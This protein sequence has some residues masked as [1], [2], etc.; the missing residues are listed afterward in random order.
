MYKIIF[1]TRLFFILFNT[2]LKVN[3]SFYFS[4]AHLFVYLQSKEH[5][6]KSV[7]T[8]FSMPLCNF[9]KTKGTK[10]LSSHHI[11]HSLSQIDWQTT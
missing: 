2:H 8:N 9:L 1:E 3:N 7:K 10:Y 6:H 4:I 5:K 11:R